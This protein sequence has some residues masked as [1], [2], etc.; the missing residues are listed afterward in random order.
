MKYEYPIKIVFTGGACS[1][2]TTLVEELER[3]HPEMF[4]AP[5]V[6]TEMIKSELESQKQ[7]PDYVPKVPWL[8]YSIFG[9]EH[10]RRSV[11]TE[12]SIPDG[13]IAL[14]DRSILDVAAYYQI[15]GHEDLIPGVLKL[16][17]EARYSFAFMCDPLEEYVVTE[18]RREP[19]EE[20]ARISTA[21]SNVYED[22]GME[23]FA[24]KDG[25]VEA[26][27]DYVDSI[28]HKKGLIS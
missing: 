12:D 8:D 6:A 18:V 13:A 5:E 3:R 10:N 14:L 23:I 21:I 7:D 9:E 4:V 11:E 2:K 24:V 22:S 17:R 16:A 27:A 28:L 25:S 26:R 19:A 15:R 1:G 20:I